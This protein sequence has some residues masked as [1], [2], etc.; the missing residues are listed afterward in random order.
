MVN[1][2]KETEQKNMNTW[3][4]FIVGA[5][6]VSAGAQ[7]AEWNFVAFS[8]FGFISGIG[9]MIAVLARVMGDA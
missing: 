8:V 7:F 5:A 9:T 1:L 3:V 6:L 2:N 4:M